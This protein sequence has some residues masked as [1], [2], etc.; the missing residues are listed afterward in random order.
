MS[1]QIRIQDLPADEI[2]ELLAL[3]GSDLSEQQ[4]ADL[5]D[6]IERIGGIENAYDAI[7]MLSQL[8]K[9]T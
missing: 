7:E 9:A 1:C 6:F 8:E 4:A 2:A 5:R 3:E